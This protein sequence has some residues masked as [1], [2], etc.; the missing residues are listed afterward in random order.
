MAALGLRGDQARE[1]ID[2][3]DGVQVLEALPHARDG[4]AVAHGDGEIIRHL[5]VELLGD[6]ERDGL[7]AL[8]EVRIDGRIAVIPAPLVDGLFGKLE[9]LFIVALDGDHVRAEGHQLR[10]LALGRALGNEDKGLDARSRGIARKR[11]RRIAGGRAG[12][13]LRARLRSLGDSHGRGAIF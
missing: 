10:D 3:T 7:L 6:L 9:R 12:D 2:K 11:A 13:D 5:P 8:G 1:L 4:A